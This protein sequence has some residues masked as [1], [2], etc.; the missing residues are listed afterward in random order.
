MGYSSQSPW[1]GNAPAAVPAG[2]LFLAMGAVLLFWNGLLACHAGPLTL[3]HFHDTPQ[4]QLLARNRLAGETG[5]GE[6]AHTVGREGRHPMWRP[7]LV[8]VEET[9]ARGLGSVRAGAAAASALGTTLLEVAMLGLAW[10]CFGPASFALTVVFLFA[11]FTANAFFVRLAVGQGPE[12][13][14]AAFTLLALTALFAARE[15]ASWSLAL[16][17]GAIAG[18]AEWFR[19]GNWLLFAVPVAIHFFT[20]LRCRDRAGVKLTAAA[21]AGY[22]GLVAVGD[23]LVPS[24]VPKTVVN[25]RANLVE[26]QGPVLETVQA[27]GTATLTTLAGLQ[28]VP[29]TADTCVDHLVRTSR[30]QGTATFLAEHGSTVLSLYGERLLQVMRGAASALRSMTG[31][32]ILVCFVLSIAASVFFRDRSSLDALAL[33]AGALAQFLGPITLLTGNSPSVYLLVV[34][35]L[36]VLVAAHGAGR[37]ANWALA[38]LRRREPEAPS[39]GERLPSLGASGSLLAFGL[40]AFLTARFHLDAWEKLRELHCQTQAEQTALDRLELAGQRVACRSMAWFVD[41][42]VDLVMLP[43]A[44]AEELADYLRQRGAA[45]LLVRENETEVSARA[46]PYGSL[47][48]FEAALEASGQFASPQVSGVWRWYRL[49]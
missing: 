19:T 22:F 36:I 14:A 46:N 35:P 30:G 6:S 28:I 13:W 10:R 31:T 37:L 8:W 11:P 18:L 7:G 44:R 49:K 5:V 4:Y 45:G 3:T 40:V 2:R 47:E 25:L 29:G 24:S 23:L 41:R 16:A 20:A 33:A 48:S 32:L 9:L 17:A 43:Y 26:S 21:L 38:R 39:E 1:C 42:D 15:R 34:L 27:D 12:P